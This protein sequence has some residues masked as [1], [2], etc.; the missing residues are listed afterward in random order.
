MR[1]TGQA[2]VLVV[3]E[4][5]EAVEIDYALP[6]L[7]LSG[8][9]NELVLWDEIGDHESLVYEVGDQEATAGALHVIRQKFVVNRITANSMEP[10][11]VIGLYEPGNDRYTIHT[12][13]HR[14]CAFRTSYLN[15]PDVYLGPGLVL[16]KICRSHF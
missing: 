8:A 2:V 14:P 13:H 16:L 15:P 10:R 7:S 11:G 1:H 4:T 5:A 6:P 3:T 9:S 12:G